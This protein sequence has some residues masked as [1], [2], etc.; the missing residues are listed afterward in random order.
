MDEPDDTCGDQS[1]DG[2]GKEGVRNTAVML[3]GNEGSAKTHENV[4]IGGFGGERHCERSVGCFAV[5]AGS[6]QAGSGHEMSDG[7]H[8]G[9]HT[10]YRGAAKKRIDKVR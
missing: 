2:C 4:E 8:S 1:D 7:V 3:E 5:E 10:G 9:S 6:A